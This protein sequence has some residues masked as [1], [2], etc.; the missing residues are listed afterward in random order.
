MSIYNL[1]Y[2]MVEESFTKAVSDLKRLVKGAVFNSRT[3]PRRSAL[4][5]LSETS[6]CNIKYVLSLLREPYA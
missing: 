6:H 5:I 2:V 1:D 4:S 3:A